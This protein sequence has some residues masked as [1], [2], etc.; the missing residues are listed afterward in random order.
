MNAPVLFLA[1]RANILLLSVVSLAVYALTYRSESR[2]SL[3][4]WGFWRSPFPSP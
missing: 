1:E 4:A 2:L 3:R